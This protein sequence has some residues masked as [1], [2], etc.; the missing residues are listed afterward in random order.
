M[1][2]WRSFSFLHR[3]KCNAG[4]FRNWLSSGNQTRIQFA[5]RVW[6]SFICIMP[7]P[8][9]SDLTMMVPVMCDCEAGDA[10]GTPAEPRLHML[11]RE[12]SGGGEVRAVEPRPG[13]CC[14]QFPESKF[15]RK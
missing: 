11:A 7:F 9:C 1:L 14:F 15:G 2:F 8:G 5:E 12:V 13:P 4:K 6:V 3:K 10:M